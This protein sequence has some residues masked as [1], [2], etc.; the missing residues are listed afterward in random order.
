MKIGLSSLRKIYLV[1][2]ILEN[3]KTYLY[4]DKVAD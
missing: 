1:Y 4:G 3:V 2:G